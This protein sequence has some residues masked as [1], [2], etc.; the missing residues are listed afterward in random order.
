MGRRYV[1]SLPVLSLYLFEETEVN[2]E[3]TEE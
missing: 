3:N 1:A 2:H